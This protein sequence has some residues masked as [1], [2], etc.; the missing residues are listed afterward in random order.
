MS[1]FVNKVYTYISISQILFRVPLFVY[2]QC[3]DE[4]IFSRERQNLP[5]Y[6]Y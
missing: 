5:M 6:L 3:C 4:I 1:G 2:G